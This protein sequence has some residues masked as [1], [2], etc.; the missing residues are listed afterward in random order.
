MNTIYLQHLWKPTTAT[1]I[2]MTRVPGVTGRI[3]YRDNAA[4]IMPDGTSIYDTQHEK[5]F[6]NI[7]DWIV[8]LVPTP[9]ME[10]KSNHI[11]TSLSPPFRSS[12]APSNPLVR[13]VQRFFDLDDD[14]DDDLF[15]LPLLRG[16]VIPSR[17]ATY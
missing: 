6:Q 11:S 5:H 16:S 8:Y 12:T 7:L 2:L 10:K 13:S 15:K 3:T 17:L 14:D 1:E 4:L 9:Q